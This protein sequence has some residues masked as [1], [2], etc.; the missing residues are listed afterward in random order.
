MDSHED[1]S[2]ESVESEE[3]ITTK[4]P[5]KPIGMFVTERVESVTSIPDSDK[6]SEKDET[7]TESVEQST[8]KGEEDA[9]K[10]KPDVHAETTQTSVEEHIATEPS[11][12]KPDI[13]STVVAET[14]GTSTESTEEQED[15]D[16][17]KPSTEE[18]ITD[19][20]KPISE[21]PTVMIDNRV[22]VENETT[23][24]VSTPGSEYIAPTTST[25]TS[26]ETPITPA[27]VPQTNYPQPPSYG[28]SQYYPDD[29]YT[30]EDEAEVF[31]PGTCRYGGKLYVSAQQ[32]P[33][34]DP[35]DFCFC[36][37]SDI[38]CLQQSCPPPIAGCHEE[39]ISGFCCPRYECPVSMATVL[40]ITTSTT[41]TSTTLPP[42][43]LHHSYGGAVERN[44]CQ[45]NG[46]SYKVG[47]EIESKSGPCIRCT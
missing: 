23:S 33:R 42:H 14:T 2:A 3:E 36:F 32:I 1:T 10:E 9:E 37:R 20:E 31:G 6:D 27:S 12:S 30:D 40:N 35:C 7:I 5:V 22:S 41:T 26:T 39:P 43:F 29:E 45:I 8:E 44:G 24:A 47:E 46:R 15:T 18:E 11:T 34:D 16:K 4:I 19:V 17:L 28:S 25:T 13:S 21:H 38:I